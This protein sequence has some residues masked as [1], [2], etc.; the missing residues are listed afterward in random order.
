MAGHS[1]LILLCFLLFG[2]RTI[3]SGVSELKE[4]TRPVKFYQCN[5]KSAC[6]GQPNEEINVTNTS[7]KNFL[8]ERFAIDDVKSQ[9]NQIYNCKLVSPEPVCKSEDRELTMLSCEFNKDFCAIKS[10]FLQRSRSKEGGIGHYNN[11]YLFDDFKTFFSEF[12]KLDYKYFLPVYAI[13]EVKEILKWACRF[14]KIQWRTED[15]R[16]QGIEYA[17]LLSED[18]VDMQLLSKVAQKDVWWCDEGVVYRG[19]ELKNL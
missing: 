2:C 1:F 18:I 12:K 7:G 16:K 19:G 6:E 13:R 14:P 9:A 11:A 3:S 10:Q 4:V 5:I 17:Y 15:Y 8:T